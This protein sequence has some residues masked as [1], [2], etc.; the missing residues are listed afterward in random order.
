MTVRFI[1]IPYRY[2][3]CVTAA[4]IVRHVGGFSGTG[5]QIRVHGVLL[6]AILTHNCIAWSRYTTL[7]FIGRSK[8]VLIV[9]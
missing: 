2:H 3:I 8:S 6:E 4:V 5:G 1:R 9:E 7:M